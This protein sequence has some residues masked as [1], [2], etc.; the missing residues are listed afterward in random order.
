[1][2]DLTQDYSQF[3]PL[4]DDKV[5]KQS[6]YPNE[7]YFVQIRGDAMLQDLPRLYDIYVVYLNCLNPHDHPEE[8]DNL[9]G[10]LSVENGPK[11]DSKSVSLAMESVLLGFVEESTIVAEILEFL[12]LDR[13]YGFATVS[14]NTFPDAEHPKK[15]EVT[16][17]FGSIGDWVKCA[18]VGE[19]DFE[20]DLQRLQRLALWDNQQHLSLRAFLNSIETTYTM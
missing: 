3:D 1:M 8:I 20:S 9:I 19:K 14:R 15:E 2:F 4:L 13:C 16:F 12:K 17:H 18:I 5:L 11:E 10:N 7:I 6:M